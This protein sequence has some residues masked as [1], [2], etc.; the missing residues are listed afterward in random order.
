MP[1][2]AEDMRCATPGAFRAHRITGGVLD[3]EYRLD[4]VLHAEKGGIAAE[5]RHNLQTRRNM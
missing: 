4:V 2:R 1:P 3:A 5:H